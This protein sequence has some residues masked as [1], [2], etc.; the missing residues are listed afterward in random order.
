MTNPDIRVDMT[1]RNNLIL[2][3][4][5]EAGI[6]SVAELCRRI[7][8]TTGANIQQ[9]QVGLLVNLKLP[10]QKRN[11]AWI[12]TALQLANFFRCL[13]E[14]LFSDI[15]QRY[16]LAKNRVRAEFVFAEIAQLTTDAVP[17]PEAL[18]CAKEFAAA[19]RLAICTLTP[20]QQRV[21]KLRFGFGGPE[22]TLA[23]IGQIIG[24]STER[25][26]AIEA[27]SLRKLKFPSRS[28]KILAAIGERPEVSRSQYY[29][30]VSFD[31][32]VLAALCAM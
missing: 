22:H 31:G 21:I 26:R 12:E 8:A 28:R 25:V 24:L 5:E 19:V 10:A 3:K 27:K 4:M 7:R 17:T 16:A 29:P 9:T 14:D 6:T 11:G 32:T 20:R 1:V 2:Q 30:D 13:P 23:E 18:V 15:Q